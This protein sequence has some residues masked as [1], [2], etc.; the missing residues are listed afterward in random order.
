M[1]VTA[2]GGKERG[3]IYYT[4]KNIELMG[5]IFLIYKEIQKEAGANSFMRKGFLINSMRKFAN[6]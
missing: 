1:A 4:V 3:R 2:D 6:I 5:E